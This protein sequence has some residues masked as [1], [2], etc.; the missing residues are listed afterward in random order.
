MLTSDSKGF[1]CIGFVTYMYNIEPKYDVAN[2]EKYDQ[3]ESLDGIKS[4][5]NLQI[6]DVIR[7]QGVEIAT[8]EVNN[9]VQIYAGNGYVWESTLSTTNQSGVRYWTL[10][11]IR[12]WY[13][14]NT[15]YKVDYFRYKKGNK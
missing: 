9:H 13:R 5:K 2:F 8:G 6:G 7:W 14:N 4:F 12:N 3:F 1:N 11:S 15:T 10:S